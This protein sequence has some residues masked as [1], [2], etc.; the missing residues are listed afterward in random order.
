[1]KVLVTG[2]NG[3]L[4]HALA[5][6]LPRRGY[7]AV[8]LS[9]ALLDVTDAEAVTRELDAHRPDA[10][11]QCAAYTRVD[12]AESHEADALAING[13]GTR[14]VAR[15]CSAIG[16]RL[17]YP[18]TDYV[19]DGSAATPYPPDHATAPLNAYGR[20]KLAGERAAAETDSLIVRTAWLYGAG[21]R[22]FVR[23]ILERARSGQPLRVVND[24]QGAP[25]WT[26]DLARTMTSLLELGAAAGIY[27]A[28][29]RGVTTW[30]GLATAACEL[31]GIEID[32]EAVSSAEFPVPARRPSYSV[33]DC[34]ATYA[35]TG[36]GVHWRDALAEAIRSGSI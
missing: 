22:N 10:V 26:A 6:E 35:L 18:S 5:R 16:A 27:H 20:T 29:N 4:A 25:T 8:V 14:N 23:T 21:G 2:G 30:H 7:D 9:R 17:V 13:E 36:E 34:S 12:D 19:F 15:A 3:M 11:V 24:Q 33:L 28:T 32:I 1:M 31:A